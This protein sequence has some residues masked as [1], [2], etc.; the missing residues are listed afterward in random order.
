[1]GIFA[2]YLKKNSL[3]K[4]K[5][6]D[7]DQMTIVLSFMGFLK[8]KFVIFGDNLQ[9]V[10]SILHDL[11]ICKFLKQDCLQEMICSDCKDRKPDKIQDIIQEKQEISFTFLLNEKTIDQIGAILAFV[12][13]VVDVL[14]SLEL[15]KE[16]IKIINLLDFGKN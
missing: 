3:D 4:K 2:L 1:M 14:S 6:W 16:V 12:T 11:E 5:R 9:I 10:S 15:S 7:I 8:E 13:R